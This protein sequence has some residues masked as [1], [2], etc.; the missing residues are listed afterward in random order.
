MPLKERIKR[1]LARLIIGFHPATPGCG[2]CRDLFPSLEVRGFH[3]LSANFPVDVVYTWVD[4]ADP[5]HAAKR[6]LYQPEQANIHVNG[7][8]KARFRDNQELR[9]SLRALEQ[10][11]PWVRHVILA[12]DGQHPD[13]IDLDHP[14]LRIVDHK[15]FIPERYLPTFNS[16]VIEAYLHNIP[17]LAEHY[18]YLNDDVFLGRPTRKTDFFTAN[19]MPIA[20][21]DWRI[22]RL[23]GYWYTKT[24]HAQSY[25]NTLELL[26][27]KGVATNPRFITAHGPY[28]ETKRNVADAFVFYKDVIERFSENRFR[29]TE[30]I[31]LYSHG[32]PLWM[33]R[34][35]KLAPCDDRFY[36]VQTRRRDRIAYYRGILQSREDGAPP[37]FFCI[38]DVGDDSQTDLWQDDFKILMTNYYSKPSSFEKDV[39]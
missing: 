22:R 20:F 36:Y 26:K 7:L 5:L 14:K 32:L 10:F 38:N 3:D 16:H 29:T 25:Y 1:A 33:F 13:W 8:E 12:T 11:A 9:Y 21:V 31:A 18:I 37:L 24:P 17:G 2:P 6:A 23:F 4:G 39:R 30:E 34:Q 27:Q 28:A 15:D 19:G 35:K